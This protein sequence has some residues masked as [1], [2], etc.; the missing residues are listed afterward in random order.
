MRVEDDQSKGRIVSVADGAHRRIANS[1]VPADGHRHGR[2]GE[3]GGQPRF[4]AGVACHIVAWDDVDVAGV[5]H[6]D[7]LQHVEVPVEAVAAVEQ[8]ILPN[9][10]RRAPGRAAAEGREPRHRASPPPPPRPSVPTSRG[11]RESHERRHIAVHAR[12]TGGTEG[13]AHKQLLG[14][15]RLVTWP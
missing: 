14:M 10:L 13:F 2:L 8:R 5:R 12:H 3:N 15:W 11:Y 1:M 7:M 4:Q 9:F 6:D